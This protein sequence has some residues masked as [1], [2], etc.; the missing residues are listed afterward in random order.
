MTEITGRRQITAPHPCCPLCGYRKLG[1][2][3][4]HIMFEGQ[5]RPLVICHGCYVIIQVI[6]YLK[7]RGAY[8]VIE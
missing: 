6:E 5:D 8:K 3:P 4:Y 7:I 2:H 1:R